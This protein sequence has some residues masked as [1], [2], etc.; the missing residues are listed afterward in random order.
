MGKKIRDRKG[1]IGSLGVDREFGNSRLTVESSSR[2]PS[3]KSREAL[4][5]AQ[6]DIRKTPRLC[7]AA[8]GAG[9]RQRHQARPPGRYHAFSSTPGSWTRRTRATEPESEISRS[10]W[11]LPRCTATTT[12]DTVSRLRT[13]RA[14]RHLTNRRLTTSS[15]LPLEAAALGLLL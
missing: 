15:M 4:C 3:R 13:P 6:A 14:A 7:S 10:T 2:A 12:T 5:S 8:A 9:A 11:V 1:G